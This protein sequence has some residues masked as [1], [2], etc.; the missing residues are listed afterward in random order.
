MLTGCRKLREMTLPDSSPLP[1]VKRILFIKLIEQGATVL[2][3]AA[4]RRAQDLVGRENVFFL[5]FEENREILEIMDLLPRENILGIRNEGFV[6]F[7]SD[8]VKQLLAIRRQ[9]IDAAVDMEFFARA[10]AVISFLT[11]ARR[12]AGLHRFTSEIPYRGDLMT[13]RLQHNPYLHTA[14]AYLLLVEALTL[15]PDEL[16]LPKKAVA[17][18]PEGPPAFSA[19]PEEMKAFCQALAGW[20]LDIER[21]RPLI[22]LNPN[23]SDMLPL[24]KWPLEYFFSLGTAILRDYPAATLVITGGATE[25]EAAG[26]L[27]QRWASAGVINMTGKTTLRELLMLYTL[28]DVLVTNDSGPAHF[29]SLTAV[30]SIVLYGPETPRLFGPLSKN[31]HSL[32][33]RLACSPC[34]NAFNHRFSPCRNNLCLQAILP[35]EVYAKVRECLAAEKEAQ[36]AL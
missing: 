26:K 22:I 4:I 10:S 5:V 20:G 36:D 13:H 29:A 23:A 35:E 14:S 12:R 2:A 27:C 3:A 6:T 32:Y 18:L 24:R 8:L 1:P 25:K 31:S 30:Q 9:G 17:P 19:Q 21:R 33:A 7:L 28:A 34:V 15:P 16:P 11:G